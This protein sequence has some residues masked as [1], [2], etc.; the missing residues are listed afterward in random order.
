MFVDEGTDGFGRI[1]LACKASTSSA[2]DKVDVVLSIT[3]SHHLSLDCEYIVR[4]N[5][6][7]ADG[8]LIAAILGEDIRQQCTSSV[9]GWVMESCVRDYK[10]RS[11]QLPIAHGDRW[12]FDCRNATSDNIRH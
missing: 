4:Y 9:G 7:L 10:N 8:P 2:N 3:P 5:L 12:S 1:I 11:C 6:L